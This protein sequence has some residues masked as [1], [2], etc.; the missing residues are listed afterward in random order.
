[1]SLLPEDAYSTGHYLYFTEEHI[2]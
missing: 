2:S 1:M